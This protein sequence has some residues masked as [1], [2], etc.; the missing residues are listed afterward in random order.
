MLSIVR[1]RTILVRMA[2]SVRSRSFGNTHTHTHIV[3]GIRPIHLLYGD[4]RKHKY[5]THKYIFI[6][7]SLCEGER[8]QSVRER[9]TVR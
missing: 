9:R 8:A 5:N 6:D 4:T 7:V 2:E 3:L 1:G